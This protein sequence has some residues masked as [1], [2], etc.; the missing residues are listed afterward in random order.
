MVRL[1]ELWPKR[2]ETGPE[3]TPLANMRAAKAWRKSWKRIGARFAAARASANW[4]V[5]AVPL[6]GRP[7]AVVNTKP[8]IGSCQRDPARSRAWAWESRS[9]VRTPAAAGVSGTARREDPD[10][11]STRL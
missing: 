8:G 1:T 2:A 10:L 5:I 4:W 7:V 3:S 11:T 9:A 6:R